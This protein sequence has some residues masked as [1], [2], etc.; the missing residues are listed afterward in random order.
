[1]EF[2]E[3]GLF[4]TARIQTIIDAYVAETNAMDAR[5][6]ASSFLRRA[7]WDHRATEADLLAEAEQFPIIA[8]LLDPYV[9]TQLFETIS[10]LANGQAPAKAV[11]DA[12]VA[13]FA[14]GEHPSFADSNPFNNPIHP[15]IKAAFDASEATAQADTTVVE[16]CTHII[17]SSG[18]GSLQEVAMRRASADDFE[19][20]IRGLDIDELS[21]FMR[22]MIEMRLQRSN[23]DCHFG[24]AT[25]HFMDACRAI[26]HDSTTPRLAALI[27]NLIEKTALASEL[28]LV[29]ADVV[30]PVDEAAS[31]A[32]TSQ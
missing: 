3:S 8:G 24:T 17:V 30:A 4:N 16:A 21:R 7:F 10:A 6:R 26:S 18:W 29:P 22:R 11:V 28:D 2:L 12:W 15:D 13:A 9:T 19:A 1:M 27:R 5:S 32:T 20:A 25:Q 23:Y 31:D 14:K